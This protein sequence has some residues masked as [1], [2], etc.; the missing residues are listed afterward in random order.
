MSA[1]LL[2]GW[3]SIWSRGGTNVCP[4]IP[5]LFHSYGSDSKVR[6][7]SCIT[8]IFSRTIFFSEENEHKS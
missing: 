7:I 2:V 3:L 4:E 1:H 5:V 6:E 8:E